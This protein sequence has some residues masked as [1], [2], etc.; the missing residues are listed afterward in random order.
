MKEQDVHNAA[1]F[2]K[3]KKRLRKAKPD[4]HEL[5][6]FKRL[7]AKE[8]ARLKNLSRECKRLRA[9]SDSMCR[10]DLLHGHPSAA[11]N[12]ATFAAM[13]TLYRLDAAEALSQITLKYLEAAARETFSRGSH[14]A[15][16]LQQLLSYWDGEFPFSND[17]MRAHA[18]VEGILLDRDPCGL[19]EAERARAKRQADGGY[20][21]WGL[22]FPDDTVYEKM[23]KGLCK[24]GYSPLNGEESPEKEAIAQMLDAMGLKAGDKKGVSAAKAVMRV[25]NLVYPY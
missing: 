23:A 14:A 19:I 9:K 7:I 3:F 24:C 20:K 11:R 4:P 1:D 21:G 13:G 6:I 10:A 16:R 8:K 17:P 22:A 2:E 12:R 15:G 5:A 18:L 25:R